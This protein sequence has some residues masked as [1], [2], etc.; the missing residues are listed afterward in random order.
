MSTGLTSGK[1]L[2]YSCSEETLSDLSFAVR[3]SDGSVGEGILKVASE[4]DL[5]ELCGLYVGL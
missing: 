3:S 2:G 1:Q 4:I 5:I